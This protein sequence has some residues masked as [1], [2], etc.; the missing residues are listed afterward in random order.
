M[1]LPNDHALKDQLRVALKDW[2]CVAD[3]ATWLIVCGVKH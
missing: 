1:H 3:M 2:L